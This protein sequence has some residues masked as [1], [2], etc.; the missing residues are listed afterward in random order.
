M[1]IMVQTFASQIT[2]EIFLKKPGRVFSWKDFDVENIEQKTIEQ[3][4][5]RLRRK[6]IIESV[7]P[8]RGLYYRPKINPLIGPVLPNRDQVIKAYERK[9]DTHFYMSG[10]QAANLLGL[11]NQVPAKI[12]YYTDK[13]LKP[14]YL[15]NN[16][17]SFR[18]KV[19]NFSEAQNTSLLLLLAIEYLGENEVN[20]KKTKDKIISI[21]NDKCILT[22]LSMNLDNFPKWISKFIL[23]YVI[24]LSG[25]ND[26]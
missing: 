14:F 25:H 26:G 6:K 18:R 16:E 15:G 10:A 3:N 2:Q 12:I 13:Q 1:I 7:A 21:L 5:S 4:L 9:L 19:L 22:D 8:F 23:S 17:I 11:S 24:S 20:I